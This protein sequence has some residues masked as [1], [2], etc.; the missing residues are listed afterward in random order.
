MRTLLA[1]ILLF[2]SIHLSAQ[3]TATSFS[4]KTNQH[5]IS[6]EYAAVSY[7]FAH[8]F[9]PNLVLGV[10]GQVGFATRFMLTDSSFEKDYYTTPE[11]HIQ[12]THYVK[13]KST[14][15][16]LLK[17][18]VFYRKQ[19]LKHFYL[20][21]GP[22]ASFGYVNGLISGWN[23][24]LEASVFYTYKKI[25]LGTRLQASWHLLNSPRAATGYFGIYSSP[26]VIGYNF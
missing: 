9:K 22:W 1:S 13:L 26:L 3:E 15:I 25:H 23:Y 12:G 10:R 16:D 8:Q 2:L 24:G 11:E 20:D 14:F 17:L 5:S 6:A 7:S 18:Q 4:E 21:L 19:F